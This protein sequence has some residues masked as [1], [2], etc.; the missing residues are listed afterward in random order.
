MAFWAVVFLILGIVLLVAAKSN[1]TAVPLVYVNVDAEVVAVDECNALKNNKGEHIGTT[2][3]VTITYKGED[4]E[5]VSKGYS[6]N[7][8]LSV[9]D[10]V[11]MEYVTGTDPKT[12]EECCAMSKRDMGI[13][14]L[15]GAVICII[16]AI[17]LW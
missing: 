4:G 1:L 12:A 3:R 7:R 2:C 17:A 8:S 14:A 6:F 13:A 16:I 11:Q 15:V 10:V 5:A 9:G